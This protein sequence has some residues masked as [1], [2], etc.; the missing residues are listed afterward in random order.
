M[1]IKPLTCYTLK[2][3]YYK[4]FYY[5]KKKKNYYKKLNLVYQEIPTKKNSLKLVLK[6]EFI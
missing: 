1:F 3:Y 5:K 2:K 4:K 6:N